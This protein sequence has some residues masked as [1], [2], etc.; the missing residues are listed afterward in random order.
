M[1]QSEDEQKR[2]EDGTRHND[3]A[4]MVVGMV[5]MRREVEREVRRNVEGEG[6]RGGCGGRRGR[7][8]L[9]RQE[10]TVEGEAE[11]VAG[12]AIS[13]QLI[14]SERIA[15][16]SPGPPGPPVPYPGPPGPLVPHPAPPRRQQTVE[17]C[18]AARAPGCPGQ[19][20]S[21]RTSSRHQLVTQ[22]SAASSSSFAF[23]HPSS[24]PS[25]PKVT[26]V[27]GVSC[28]LVDIPTYLSSGVELASLSEV[29]SLATA[30]AASYLVQSKENI[31]RL[32]LDI[33]RRRELKLTPKKTQW[34]LICIAVGFLTT[35]VTLVGT[36]LSYTSDYQDRA[37][38]RQLAINNI[39]SLATLVRELPL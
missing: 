10:A 29:P 19:A 16:P 32:R 26:L 28:S 24:S 5:D 14:F 39:S 8:R 12:Q 6:R 23:L 35:C 36:M 9:V 20:T 30:P 7:G 3:A 13:G 22:P 33:V 34:T 31:R 27:R 15:V 37:V 38:L 17:S 4:K 18:P 25:N 2:G 1:V 11:P 21:S